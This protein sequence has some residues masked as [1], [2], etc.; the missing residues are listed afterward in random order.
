MTWE[1]IIIWFFG[2]INMIPGTEKRIR[3]VTQ[4]VPGKQLRDPTPWVTGE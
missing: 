2:A 3:Q 4:L 1:I